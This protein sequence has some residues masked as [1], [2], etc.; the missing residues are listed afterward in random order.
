MYQCSY[1]Y[2]LGHWNF[3]KSFLKFV[4]SPKKILYYIRV[5]CHIDVGVTHKTLQYIFTW[6]DIFFSSFG[7]IP[8]NGTSGSYGSSIFNFLWILH[9]VFHGSCTVLHSPQQRARV[10]ISLE[11]SRNIFW[12]IAAF[13]FLI[14]NICLYILWLC[15]SENL[16]FIYCYQFFDIIFILAFKNWGVCVCVLF[17]GLDALNNFRIVWSLKVA[18]EFFSEK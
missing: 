8:R 15:K 18:I 7:Q 12:Y 13:Y 16:L 17:Y 14:K 5:Y 10:L 9:T 3:K 6:E 11:V 2:L 1:I 4:E